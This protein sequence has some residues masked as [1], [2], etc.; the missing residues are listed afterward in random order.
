MRMGGHELE[1]MLKLVWRIGVHFG[2][3]AH[4]GEAEP[5]EPEQRLVPRDAPLEQGVNGQAPPAARGFP[6]C[7]S[8]RDLV[9]HDP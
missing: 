3:H 4:L 1:H 2:G 6:R 5:G 9:G 8:R 7:R